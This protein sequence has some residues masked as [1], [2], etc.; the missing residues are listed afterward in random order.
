ME[1]NGVFVRFTERGTLGEQVRDEEKKEKLSQVC[2][3]KCILLSGYTLN[4]QQRNV[5]TYMT[6]SV[7]EREKEE[8][9]YS[10]R[11]ASKVKKHTL[12]LHSGAQKA[13]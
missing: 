7:S 12:S 11:R 4:R 1:I 5:H 2:T 9:S 3:V 6:L 13:A 8:R 10:D